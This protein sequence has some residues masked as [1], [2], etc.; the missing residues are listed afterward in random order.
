MPVRLSDWFK[1]GEG[2]NSKCRNSTGTLLFKGILRGHYI[3]PKL[4]VITSQK[5]NLIESEVNEAENK[6]AMA[7]AS[8]A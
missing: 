1:H 4:L 6:R 5:A 7:H 3:A 8:T 2:L